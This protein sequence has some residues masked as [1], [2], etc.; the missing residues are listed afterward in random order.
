MPDPDKLKV[1]SDLSYQVQGCCGLCVNALFAPGLDWGSCKAFSYEHAKH[2]KR[3]LSVHRAGVCASNFRVNEKKRADL[4][5]SGF[6]QLRD[7]FAFSE[8]LSEAEA[9]LEEMATGRL[10]GMA[11]PHGLSGVS[12]KVYTLQTTVSKRENCE[13][14]DE[15]G[16]A[17]IDLVSNYTSQPWYT[18]QQAEVT[19]QVVEQDE[20]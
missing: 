6:W 18:Y 8:T 9:A 4:Q 19:I 1:L 13:T 2:G 17:V 12:S 16:A 14:V 7:K 3:K 5:R 10:P 11:A 15:I 20:A